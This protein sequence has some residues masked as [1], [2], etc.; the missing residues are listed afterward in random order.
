MNDASL[1][2]QM[3][4]RPA[5][6]L[7]V[8]SVVL[9]IGG[10]AGWSL[11]APVS[12]AVIAS[13]RV[14]VADRNQSVEHVY[15]GE[16]VE[17]LVRDGDR[18]ARGDPLL[19][20]AGS[21][22]SDELRVLQE[23]LAELDA[24][25]ARLDAERSSA[26]ER[27][28]TGELTESESEFLRLEL[29]RAQRAEEHLWDLRVERKELQTRQA[30]LRSRIARLDVR[31]PTDGIV[32]GLTVNGRGDVVRPGETMMHIV[33]DASSLVVIA[34]VSPRDVDQIYAGQE[35]V[36]LFPAFP[37]R[38]TPQR[39]GRVL[40]VSADAITDSRSGASWFEAE[41]D[42][43]PAAG[44]GTPAAARAG[45]LPLVPGMPAE[46]QIQTGSRSIAS[47]LIQPLTDFFGRSLREE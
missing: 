45:D 27:A 44:A 7:G 26:S 24:R 42:I 34:E 4:A 18:V 31:A 19:R 16:V 43:E 30:L 29:E 8:L 6:L 25:V 23:H 38:A 10:V 1:D 39:A 3:S 36:I 40:R 33:P 28:S 32:L 13:G 17:V 37:L 11:L 2:R 41:L 47:Y 12:S 46:V 15:G 21:S 14:A 22:L 5:L 9:L 35:A 20:F